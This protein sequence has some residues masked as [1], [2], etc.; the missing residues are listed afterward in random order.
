MIHN[1]D[2][3]EHDILDSD[4]YYEFEGGLAAAVTAESGQ[5]PA[6]WHGD[7]SRPDAPR[8]FTL[9][10]EIARVVRARVVNPKW[11]A[12]IMRHGYKGAAEMAATV[13][14]L[15]AF[16]ATTDAVHDHQFDLVAQAYLGEADVLAFLE[17]HNPAALADIKARLKD[18]LA[19]GLWTP[20]RNSIYGLLE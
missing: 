16:A 8:I 4:E 18:A 6:Q 1:Q 13:D 11:I 17:Q 15:C 9:Q 20:R 2:N 3:R 10:E 19:R 14:Y 7:H 5:A 12:G